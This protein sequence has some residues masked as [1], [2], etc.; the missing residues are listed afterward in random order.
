MQKN[1]NSILD[2]REMCVSI[3]VKNKEKVNRVFTECGEREFTFIRRS[4]FYFGFLFGCIQTVGW[5]FYD[6]AWLLPLC[7]FIVGWFTNYVALKIIFRPVK[8]VQICGCI[9]FQG[10]FLKRQKEVSETFARINC[11]ELLNTETMWECILTGPNR[12]NFQALLRAHSIVFTE[13]LIGGL[14]PFAL[15]AMG[16]EGFAKMK[17]DV[18]TKVI[19]KMPTIIPLTYDYTTEAMDMET[20]IRK[21]MQSLSSAEFEGVLHPAFEEDEMTLIFVGGFLG[22]LVG[23]VQIFALF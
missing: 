1:I 14:R 21:S 16:A 4:G 18:A 23:I 19:E 2:I 13:N 17:E 15:A 20:T 22:M 6:G 11:V 7:G 3:C 8:P 9:N 10:L 12:G 5:L